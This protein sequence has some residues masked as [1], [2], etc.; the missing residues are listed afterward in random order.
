MLMPVPKYCKN[1]NM[2]DDTVNTSPPAIQFVPECYNTQEI[3]DKAV[4][5]CPF[6]FSSVPD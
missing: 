5:A 3:C 6:V 2:C 4:G 1:Q